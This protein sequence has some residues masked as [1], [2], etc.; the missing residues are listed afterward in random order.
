VTVIVTAEPGDEEM[1]ARIARHR[2]ARPPDWETVEAPLALEEALAAVSDEAAVVV[3]C[4][5]LW[6]ANLMGAGA[7]D[8]EVEGRASRAA[9]LAAGRA[10]PTF[11]VSNEV[12]AGIVPVNADARRFR[13]LLGTVNRRWANAARRSVLVVAGQALPL[14]DPGRLLG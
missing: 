11:T 14:S 13:D 3:D 2:A 7:P 9:V 12:G 5:T 4:L 10:A 1:S 8:Q 6:V